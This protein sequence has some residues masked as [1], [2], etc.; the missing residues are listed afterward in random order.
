MSINKKNYCK[1]LLLKNIRDSLTFEKETKI[2]CLHKMEIDR[3]KLLF[4]TFEEKIYLENESEKIFC[5]FF[6]KE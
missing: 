2:N 3:C 1:Y 4:P 6:E 5:D